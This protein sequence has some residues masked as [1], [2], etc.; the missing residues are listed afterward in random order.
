MEHDISKFDALLQSSVKPLV[1][2]GQ[3]VNLW[4]RA[5]IADSD[6][7]PQ[8]EPFLSKDCDLFGD[9]AMLQKLAQ[10][11]GWDCLFSPKG[12]PSPV[13]GYLKQKDEQGEDLIAEVLFTIR[14]LDQQD[15]QKVVHLSLKHKEY[16]TLSP[17]I[18][19]KAKL[20]NACELA[21]LTPEGVRNDVK[22]IKVLVECVRGYLRKAIIQVEQGVFSERSMVNVL[23]EVYQL[24]CSHRG[25]RIAKENQVDFLRS[26]PD[27][28]RECN[29]PK[30][31]NFCAHRK[32]FEG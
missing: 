3:A 23:E 9:A 4:A 5:F 25:V 15:M 22:H 27:E 14:G 10:E 6:V 30:I 13:V 2:G 16:R 24:I 31:Q 18:L 28:L 21:Q 17:I 11:T 20:A 7:L 32:P 1:V 19:L 26:F 29:L 8:F 12:Q